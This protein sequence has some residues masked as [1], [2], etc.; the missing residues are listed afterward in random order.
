MRKLCINKKEK[1]M[2]RAIDMEKDIDVLRGRLDRLEPALEK[3]IN[4]IDE[5]QGK[6]TKTIPVDLVEEVK[7][8]SVS[9]QR[10]NKSSKKSTKEP[11]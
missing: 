10:K 8:K 5:L 4:V 2:G 6:A 9:K 11:V 7:G 3:V 1:M